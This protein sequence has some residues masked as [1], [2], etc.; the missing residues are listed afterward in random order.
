MNLV[1]IEKKTRALFRSACEGTQADLRV[2]CAHV[3]LGPFS[4]DF[5][6][7]KRGTL[8][9]RSVICPTSDGA[10]VGAGDGFACSQTKVSGF[11]KAR[12]KVFWASH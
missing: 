4:L 7:F 10:L 3:A 12:D 5:N 2:Y 11:F 8:G 6:D 9:S 1:K